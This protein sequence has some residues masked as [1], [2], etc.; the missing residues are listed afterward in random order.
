M[1]KRVAPGSSTKRLSAS[2]WNAFVDVAE[3]HRDA[4]FSQRGGLPARVPPGFIRLR[5]NS[6]SQLPPYTPVSYGNLLATP[7]DDLERWKNEPII[8]TLEVS[9]GLFSFGVTQDYMDVDEIQDV[10]IQGVTVCAV[11]IL[12][13]GHPYAYMS[14]NFPLRSFWWG[15]AKILAKESSGTGQKWCVIQLGHGEWPTYQAIYQ[16]THFDL[17]NPPGPADSGYDMPFAP[18]EEPMPEFG[19][20]QGVVPSAGD[21]CVIHWAR[22]PVASNDLTSGRAI[23]VLQT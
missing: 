13:E 4:P 16:G 10:L 18:G 23:A 2:T 15:G 3:A 7:S 22:R 9:R 20:I 19:A 14:G 17:Q 6:G 11:N 21:A 1:L 5:N 8:N 12:S